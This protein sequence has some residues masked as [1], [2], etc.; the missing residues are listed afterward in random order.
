LDWDGT[1]YVYLP[2]VA[3][4]RLTVPDSAALDITG[5]ITLIINCT[6]DTLTVN[7]PL[8]FKS[9]TDQT[10]YALRLSS[11]NFPVFAW[12]E[13]GSISKTATSSA[14]LTTV[15][16][17]GN[18]I[19]IKVTMDVDNGASGNDV[20]FYTSTD[21]VTYTQ[22]GSTIT[23]AGTTSI[24]SGTADVW[25]G[26]NPTSTAQVLTGKVFRAQVCNGI[27]AAPVLDVDTSQVTSGAAT[28]FTALTGQTVTINRST[29]GRKTVCVV[30]P[31]WLFGTDDA[32]I[33]DNRYMAHTGT[34]YLYL[35]GISLNAATTP[36]AA[37][38]D[39]TGDIDLRVKVALDDWTPGVGNFIS[40][41]GAAS[42]RSYNFYINPNGTI[43][44]D[45]Y[46]D[47]TTV[48]TS[49]STIAPTI[50]D[51]STLW[52]RVTL[53]VDNGNSENET[54]FFTST[55]GTNWTQLG[56][57]I[58]K[59]ATTS[60]YNSTAQLAVG[61]N[62]QTSLTQTLRG[63][64]FRAMIYADITETTLAFDANF[65]TSITSLL[66]ADFTESSLNA[67]TVTIN[68]SGSTYR[69]AGITAA[70][71]LYPG[72][73]NTFSASATDFLSFGAS[74]SFTVV[75]VAKK[76]ATM[77]TFRGIIG[78]SRATDDGYYL[79]NGTSENNA[80]ISID[81]GDNQAVAQVTGGFPNNGSL[82]VLSGVINRSTQTATMYAN[83]TASST[84]DTTAVGTLNF[85][86]GNLE[87]GRR[88]GSTTI[89]AD[90]EFV[91]AAVFRRAL[92]S[93]EITT[94]YNY[95]SGRIGS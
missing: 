28:S 89:Y 61:A 21:G 53:D 88:G 95:Y 60:I 86:I 71:Y 18:N 47:G 23:T 70:G 48:L 75:A 76:Y 59:A 93:A 29:S 68:R 87:I 69:S 4:N 80:Y 22:L 38:L 33:V 78:K 12:S 73:T 91:A 72:A 92:T 58:T 74:D 37:A 25:I 65:E 90:M 5:D 56:T 14:A 30:H 9:A 13:D 45:W 84:S 27:D 41:S 94:I 50:A 44:L 32:M 8:I 77:S 85:P 57:T 55:D 34:N 46:A 35:P 52:V 10:A 62:S 3:S 39:I 64:F 82:T 81:S 54:K 11:S 40:K 79:S 43:A 42:N 24:F 49:T 7:V 20:K 83:T 51:G 66:Q 17:A 16:T 26:Q 36:D 63:K 19:W 15:Y 67:A 2:G 31:V 6:I 1:N